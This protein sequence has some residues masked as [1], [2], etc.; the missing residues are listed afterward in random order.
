MTLQYISVKILLCACCVLPPSLQASYP[1][2][3]P[4]PYQQNVGRKCAATMSFVIN[5]YLT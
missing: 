5:I 2:K 1:H 4:L 3:G